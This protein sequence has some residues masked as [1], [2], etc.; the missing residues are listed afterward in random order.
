M[1]AAHGIAGS[2]GSLC[3]RTLL[4]GARDSLGFMLG[5]VRQLARPEAQP[6][7][8]AD[9]GA[10]PRGFLKETMHS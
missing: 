6:R 5:S 9:A 2:S 7:C 8:E 4:D 1:Q 10:L 3:I